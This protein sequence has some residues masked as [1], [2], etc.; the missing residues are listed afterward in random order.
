VPHTVIGLGSQA[1]KNYGSPPRFPVDPALA[2]RSSSFCFLLFH[3]ERKAPPL[4]REIVVMGAE[5]SSVRDGSSAQDSATVKTCYYEV[6][7][8]ERQASDDE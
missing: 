5:H 3:T 1:R 4:R 2:L 8:V 6:L 7:G